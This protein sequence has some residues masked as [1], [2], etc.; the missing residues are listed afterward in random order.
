MSRY[1]INPQTGVPGPCRATKS[2]P[3]G[4]LE[5]DHYPSVAAA[6]AGFEVKMAGNVAPSVDR[7]TAQPT[8]A[9]ADLMDL[10]LVQR[11][12]D[13]GYLDMREHEDD[14]ALK[15]LC[16]SKI[17]QTHGM[18]NEVT[19]TARG[20]I[21]RAEEPD[22]SDGVIVER[23]WRKFFTLE[24]HNSGWSLGDEENPESAADN[25]SSLDFNAP[26]EVTDKMDGSMGILYRHPDGGP[27]LAT[28]GSF[29][30]DQAHYYT[31]M[32]RSSQLGE[33]AES[34]LS[35]DRDKT[36]LFEMVGRDN[37]IV[38]DYPE[39]GIVL[40][41]AV[42]KTSG[43]YLSPNDYANR[44]SG[45]V[46]ETMP[47][48]T[49]ADALALPDRPEREGVVIRIISDDPEKQMQLKVKQDDYKMLH[50]AVT[51][52]SKSDMRETIRE[53]NETI[54]DLLKVAKSK[55]VREISGVGASLE[56]IETHPGL[57]HVVRD[58]TETYEAII[59]PRLAKLQAA[60][61]RVDSIPADFFK[62]DNPAKAFAASIVDERDLDK[63]DLFTFFQG[64]L[65]GRDTNE[66]RGS[67]VLR[68]IAQDI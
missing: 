67:K 43:L 31:R 22:L 37:R 21:I 25:L 45:G 8:V 10:D 55:N 26:A 11:M 57:E 50:R 62:Q 40:L 3:F 51:G 23:P 13:E 19:K 9:L 32:L 41:G 28:K 66:L 17:A 30:S 49:V 38:L 65:S 56:L 42:Q 34:L 68:G 29:G 24:Q 64:R 35:R 53:S 58:R 36:F 20:L 7:L 6:Q 52:F 60:K 16:Y 18:W 4:D 14:P 2:C 33:D 1:H 46:T 39:D 27:A 47:V 59:L 5:A 48:A 44:W 63:A 61:E 54:G 12:R 15:V